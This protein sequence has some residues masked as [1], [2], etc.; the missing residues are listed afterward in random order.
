[1]H[2]AWYDKA[3]VGISGTPIAGAR[4]APPKA[5]WDDQQEQYE[6][7]EF[8][9]FIEKTNE[10]LEISTGIDENTSKSIVFEGH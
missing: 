8:A 7:N 5:A 6:N 9:K 1:M 2:S 3:G 10:N 4:P